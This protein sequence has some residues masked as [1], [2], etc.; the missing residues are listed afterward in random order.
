MKDVAEGTFCPGRCFAPLA[1]NLAPRWGWMEDLAVAAFYP[2]AVSRLWRE[3]RGTMERA[4]DAVVGVSSPLIATLG[5]VVGLCWCYLA[6]LP[7]LAGLRA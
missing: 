4:G 3:T 2:F 1:R 6:V 7:C 5:S